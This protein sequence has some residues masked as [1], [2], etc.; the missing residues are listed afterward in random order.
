MGKL[1]ILDSTGHTDVQ[2]DV[3][4]KSEVEEAQKQFEELVN[5][6]SHMAVRV[7]DVDGG[8]RGQELIDTFDP[9]AEEVVISPRLV[10]G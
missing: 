7:S 3:A 8:K 5:G 10:G 1:I 2:W 9:E 4:V 6:G